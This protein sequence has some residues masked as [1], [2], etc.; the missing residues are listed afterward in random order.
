MITPELY[1][2]IKVG[3]EFLVL[4]FEL[5]K[6]ISIESTKNSETANGKL[7]GQVKVPAI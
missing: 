6:V 4:D 5:S 3:N 2:M 7:F 1:K